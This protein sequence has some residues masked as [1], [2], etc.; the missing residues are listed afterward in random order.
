[1]NDLNVIDRFLDAFIRYIDSGFG[2]LGGDVAFLTS[3]LIGID[4]TLAGLFWAMG[5]EGDVIARFLKKILYV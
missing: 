5:G 1:M 2:L 4:I 3:I